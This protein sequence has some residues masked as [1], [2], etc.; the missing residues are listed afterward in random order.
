MPLPSHYI[1]QAKCSRCGGNDPNC[2]VCHSS[3]DE[4][5]PPERDY[6]D[7]LDDTSDPSDSYLERQYEIA[8]RLHDEL[9]DNYTESLNQD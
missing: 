8:D 7:D 5:E 3:T 9:R 2:H 6:S 1:G 4:P